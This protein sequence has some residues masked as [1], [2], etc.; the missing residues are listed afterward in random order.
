MKVEA[1]G[2][3]PSGDF[4]ASCDSVCDCVNCQ[5]CRA[6]NALHLECFK[7]QFLA[8]LDADLQHLIDVWETVAPSIRMV[9]AR[10]VMTEGSASEHHIRSSANRSL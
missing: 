9:I 10:L 7:R 2:I 1:A 5:Q 3:E 8:S 6:A 4:D